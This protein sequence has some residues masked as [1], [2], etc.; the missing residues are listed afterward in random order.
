MSSPITR[1]SPADSQPSLFADCFPESTEPRI[2]GATVRHFAE[3]HGQVVEL[4]EFGICPTCNNYHRTIRRIKY[5]NHPSKHGCNSL[6]MGARGPNCE[7]ACG[8]R[9]HGHWLASASD[10]DEQLEVDY[11]A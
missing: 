1:Y 8:G 6:C 9:N 5:S 3:C 2:P 4:G 7:C 10:T 11:A